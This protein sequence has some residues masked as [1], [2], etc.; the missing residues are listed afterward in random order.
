MTLATHASMPADLSG[1]RL[2]GFCDWYT[3]EAS[4]GA[5]RAAW[6]VYRRL[7]AAGARIRVISAA[8]G[9]PHRDSGVEVEVIRGFD[10][11][12]LVGG[13][14]APAPA[15]F[16]AAR[17]A[18]AAHR[19]DVV[20]VNT[21]HYTGCIAGARLAARH[22]IPLVV[23]AQ[24]G[25]L[26]H[27][28]GATR[29]LAAAYERLVGGYIL[30]RAS[31]V[32]AVSKSA[33]AQAVSLGAR[34]DMVSLA[35]NGADHERFDVAP[36]AAGDNP[37]VLAIGRL[38]ANKGPDLLLEAAG[39]LAGEG[40]RFR[41]AFVG[42]GPMRRNLEERVRA[43]GLADRVEFP[44]QVADVERWVERAEIVVRAS[45]TE[46]LA[47]AVLEAMAAGRCNVVSDIPPNLELIKD[48]GN[49]LTFRSG[50][51]ADLARVLR[52]SLRD[53][54]LRKRLGL[55]ARE[56]AQPFT[57]DN[58]AALHGIALLAC[59]RGGGMRSS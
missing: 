8:H 17:R 32:L 38:T 2:L 6:E 35:P 20:H 46:G 3:P 56:D 28:P 52:A 31:R 21:I 51:V 24:L 42:D 7:G 43:L 29:R 13:Y 4:G 34:P 1:L 30:R 25:S 11:S 45:Y 36:L 26:D 9:P 16:L 47:L 10:L 39:T 18:V 50:D 40:E 19:P 33:G 12:S 14:L 44:G 48:G 15:A 55:Q 41:L 59:A 54:A 37:L 49:G 58:M 5:E 53:G 27:L 57:W 22:G 23:T